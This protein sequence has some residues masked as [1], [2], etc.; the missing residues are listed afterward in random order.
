MTAESTATSAVTSFALH[1]HG[2]NADLV[3]ALVNPLP[4]G[5]DGDQEGDED[6]EEK[7]GR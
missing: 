3:Q 4:H 2:I 7:L 1:E 5:K 6:L